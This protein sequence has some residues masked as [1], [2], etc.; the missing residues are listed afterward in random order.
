MSKF[1]LPLLTLE[2]L[3]PPRKL[4]FFY[5]LRYW[6][7]TWPPPKNSVHP[8]TTLLG[9]DSRHLLS[10]A[11]ST[12]I[13]PCQAAIGAPIFSGQTTWTKGHKGHSLNVKKMARN[14]RFEDNL[15]MY[16]YLY[17]DCLF[18]R[19]VFVDFKHPRSMQ[20]IDI[21]PNP[22]LRKAFGACDG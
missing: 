14:S 4:C 16:T 20:Y 10:Q 21:G 22:F 11:F 13:R 17:M 1:P 9:V 18:F 15:Y 2:L 7:E 6:E 8:T 12:Q 5:S 19:L 3:L